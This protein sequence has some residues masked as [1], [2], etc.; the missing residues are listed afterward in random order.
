MEPLQDQERGGC[1]TRNAE[2]F[3]SSGGNKAFRKFEFEFLLKIADLL[4][5]KIIL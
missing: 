2:R 5:K 1:R 4:R 3:T